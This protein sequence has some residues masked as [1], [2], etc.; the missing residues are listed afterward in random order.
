MP[1]KG[2]QGFFDG[3]I[4]FQG[5]KSVCGEAKIARPTLTEVT[6]TCV[7]DFLARVVCQMTRQDGG[8]QVLRGDEKCQGFL[9]L[10]LILDEMDSAGDQARAPQ[11]AAEILINEQGAHP[12]H[13]SK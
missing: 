7:Q 2:F 5:E 1:Q 9:G 12:D 8:T 6:I 10:E 13:G 11:D 3:I 4:K